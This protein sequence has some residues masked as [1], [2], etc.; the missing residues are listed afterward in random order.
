MDN[1]A[2]ESNTEPLNQ[3]TA[4]AAFAELIEREEQGEQ[5]AEP[6]EEPVA[7]EPAEEPAEDDPLVTIKVDGKEVQVPLSEV[8]AGYQR[9]ADYTRKTMEVSE[10]RKA[11]EAEIQRAQAERQM[12]AVNLQKMQA[13]IEGALQQQQNIDWQQLLENDPQEYLKQ[14][15]LFEQR[16]AALQQNL[17]A[18]QHIAAQMQAEQARAL[19]NHIQSQQQ[20]LLAKLPE[21]KDE[22][23]AKAEKQALREYLL[24]QGYDQQSVDTIADARAVV[25]A[26]KAYLYDQMMSKAQAAQKKVSTLPTKV[27]RPGT[28]NAPSI[29]RRTS[30]F[31]RLSKSGRVED[32]A[33]VFAS[34]L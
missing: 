34:L 4:A 11:A 26:R 30:A 2:T 20:E 3:D 23:K 27:E 21:W 9:Q 8:K 14:K 16:Q 12:Y 15:H 24:S 31:Q 29:D 28:G 10:Q 18:Q 1:P 32:A 5:P 13:Q 33:A 25:L 19:Q 17:T 6:A 7:E 22:S